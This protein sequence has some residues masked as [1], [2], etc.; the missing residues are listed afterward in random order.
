[1]AAAYEEARQ[2]RARTADEVL[3]AAEGEAAALQQNARRSPSMAVPR[4]GHPCSST[5]CSP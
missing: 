1:M 5:G 4:A 3:R 2:V